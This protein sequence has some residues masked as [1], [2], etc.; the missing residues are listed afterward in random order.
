MIINIDL[1]NGEDL[2]LFNLRI[3]NFKIVK[4]A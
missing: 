3:G 1:G 4:C 2:N